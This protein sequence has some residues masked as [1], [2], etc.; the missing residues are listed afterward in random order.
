MF[1]IAV[2]K[3]LR[4]LFYSLKFY[5]MT[6]YLLIYYYRDKNIINEKKMIRLEKNR[7]IDLLT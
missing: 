3:G 4:I 6:K 5:T 2:N 7:L 1:I